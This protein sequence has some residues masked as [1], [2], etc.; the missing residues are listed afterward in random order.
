MEVYLKYSENM[1]Q[2]YKRTPMPKCDFSKVN[3]IEITLRRKCS[4]VNLV[5]NFRT[6]PENTCGGRPLNKH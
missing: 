3:F 4:P 6:P 5:H 1:E 2:I